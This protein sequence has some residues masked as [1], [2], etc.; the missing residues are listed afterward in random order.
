MMIVALSP[1]RTSTSRTL[2]LR[3]ANGACDIS[4]REEGGAA[5]HSCYREIA[6]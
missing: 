6:A 3:G 5:W 1:T 4:L 2:L